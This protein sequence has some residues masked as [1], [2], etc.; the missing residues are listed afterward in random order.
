MDKPFAFATFESIEKATEVLQQFNGQT[1]GSQMQELSISYAKPREAVDR[2]S[3][4][5]QSSRGDRPPRPKRSFGDRSSG[6]SEGS[7]Y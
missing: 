1:A 5:G 6:H 3:G 2:F 4:G 7:H